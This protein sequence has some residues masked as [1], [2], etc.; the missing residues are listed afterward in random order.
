MARDLFSPVSLGTLKLRNR[1]IMAPLTRCRAVE[2]NVPSPSAPLYY[3]QRSTAGLIVSEATQVSPQGVGYSHTPGIYSPEQVAGWKKVTE[4][5]HAKGGLIFLQLWHVGAKSHPDFHG[6]A[7]PVAPSAVN[8][9]LPINTPNGPTQTVTPRA[10]ERAEI[11]QLVED[12]RQGAKNAKA[13][14]FD[15]VEVHGANGYLPNQFLHDGYN[16]RTDDYGGSI[17]NRARFLLQITHAVSEVMGSDRVGVRISPWAKLADKMNSHAEE[18][19]AYVAA[20]LEKMEIAYLHL[21]EPLAGQPA[22]TKAI[23]P[24][25]RKIFM[26][27]LMVNGGY[28]LDTG[29]RAIAS[30]LA[31]M[32]S[33]GTLFIA[34]PDLPERFKRGAA[35]NPVDK[36][37]FYTHDNK[38]YTDYPP[39]S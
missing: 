14:G 16:Q 34:N 8:P 17:E 27:P 33:Y 32:V 10:L 11:P 7:L 30:G 2:G 15:G 38:G 19:F 36:S 37:T 25:L 28:G 9:N 13:A 5:V 1:I 4:A 35:L 24:G 12:F 18:T 29:N 20:E 3:A 26:G 6:G 31:D 39:L 21:L 22:G 23:G